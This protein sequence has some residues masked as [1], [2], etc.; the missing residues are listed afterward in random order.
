MLDTMEI[1]VDE[2]LQQLL[3]QFKSTIGKEWK[4]LKRRTGEFLLLAKDELNSDVAYENLLRIVSKK[5]FIP[6]EMLNVCQRIAEGTLTEEFVEYAKVANTIKSKVKPENI[7]DM[8]MPR[9]IF[10][11]TQGGLVEKPPIEMDKLEWATNFGPC[12]FKSVA[13]AKTEAVK[14][15]E[16]SKYFKAH[17]YE[18][19]E[20]YLILSLDKP[21][22]FVKI[23]ITKDLIK[24]LENSFS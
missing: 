7:P 21:K 22:I 15:T 23:K 4:V 12:G 19:I 20:G 1:N 17:K 2:K 10:S 13:E 9:K 5:Y 18:I 11:P 14:K 3:D 16:S 24:A 6:K 8:H